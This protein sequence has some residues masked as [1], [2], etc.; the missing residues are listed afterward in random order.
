MRWGNLPLSASADA[1]A[2]RRDPTSDRRWVTVISP[3]LS[4][5]AVFRTHTVVRLLSARFRVQLI[6]FDGSAHDYAP[7]VNSDAIAAEAR[8]YAKNIAT[9][10]WRVRGLAKSIRGEAIVAVKPMLGSF[11]AALV[12]GRLIKCPVLV[13]I[14]DWEP[15]FLSSAPYWEFRKWGFQWFW[16]TASPLYIRILNGFMYRAS[17]VTVSNSFLQA[18]YGGHWLPHA[19]DASAFKPTTIN[20][21]T[22]RVVL[23]AGSPRGHKGLPTLLRVWKAL[24]RTDAILQ[25]AV[26]DPHDEFLVSLR[27]LDIP[28][29]IVTGPHPFD[30]MPRV[31]ANAAVVVVPQDNVSGSVGQLPMKLID[32][33]VAAK[34]IVATDVCDAS[35]WLAGGAGIVVVPGS[36]D[37]LA[38]GLTYALDHPEVWDEMGMKARTRLLQFA[39]ESFLENRLCDVLSGLLNGS[40]VPPL[41]AF[42]PRACSNV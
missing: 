34:P 42:D 39:S 12:L 15:G 33:M 14:D 11:G 26:P 2:T 4:G 1:S 41:T 38:Q 18:L 8:Y 27:P 7:L 19:R 6:G 22:A 32:A 29:V 20:D 24:S 21:A 3:T 36:D 28:N 23:F 13:D 25:L 9:W 37:A 16:G 31:L 17:A 5:N 35:R 30:Q 10:L 40:A